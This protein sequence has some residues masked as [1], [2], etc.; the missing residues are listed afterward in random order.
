[1]QQF[2]VKN[3]GSVMKKAGGIRIVLELISNIA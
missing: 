2:V 1:M 3:T